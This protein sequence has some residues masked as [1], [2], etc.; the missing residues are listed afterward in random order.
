MLK[1]QSDFL[2]GL[3]LKDIDIVADKGYYSF[4]LFSLMKSKNNNLIVPPK[5]YGKKSVHIIVHWDEIFI[6]FLWKW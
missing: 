2:K 6:K 1:L 4:G 3:N 5:N